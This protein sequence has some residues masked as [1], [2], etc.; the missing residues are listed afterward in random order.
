M[1]L[2]CLVRPVVTLRLARRTGAAQI[3]GFAP[4]TRKGSAAVGVEGLF[5]KRGISVVKSAGKPGRNPLTPWNHTYEEFIQKFPSNMT[6]RPAQEETFRRLNK[7]FLKGKRFGLVEMS[8]GG[9]KSHVAKTAADV[10]AEEGGAF[11]ITAQKALQD[12][13]QH[14][15]PSPQMELLK[16]RANYACTHPEASPNMDAGHAVC[17]QRKKGILIDCIDDQAAGWTNYSDGEPK[18][19][20][21]AAVNLTLPT[22]AH[23]C[24]YWEQLQKCNDHHLSL[25]NFSSFLF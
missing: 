12:Q 19:I 10:V 1:P 11:M 21:N 20:L 13:Y 23:L 8:T 9:G 15:F 6:P 25:F 3:S 4:G 14:D 5:Q 16:G 2:S 22:C 7:A 17:H 24:P 18:G